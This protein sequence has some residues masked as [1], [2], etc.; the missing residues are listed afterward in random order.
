MKVRYLDN[1]FDLSFQKE[2]NDVSSVI[3]YFIVSYIVSLHCLKMCAHGIL[4]KS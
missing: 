2:N 4:A 1:T 3:S